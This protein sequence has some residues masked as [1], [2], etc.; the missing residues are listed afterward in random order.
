MAIPR[1]EAWGQDLGELFMEWGDQHSTKA[2]LA[3]QGGV[4]GNLTAGAVF[5]IGVL[6]IFLIGV[7]ETRPSLIFGIVG[8]LVGARILYWW[9]CWIQPAKKWQ[10][11]K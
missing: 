6:S 4:L 11:T 5:V 8:G 3:Y 2:E 1:K 10:D 9:L 7:S